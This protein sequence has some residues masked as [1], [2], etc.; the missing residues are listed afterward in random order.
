MTKGYH[1]PARYVIHTVGPLYQGG[2]RGEPELLAACY[3]NCL[4]LAEDNG[5]GSLAF[6]SIGAG[7]YGYPLVEAARIA[8]QTAKDFPNCES[9]LKR[10]VYCCFPPENTEVYRQVYSEIWSGVEGLKMKHL[11]LSVSGRVQGVFFRDTA[12]REAEKLGINGFARNEPNGTVWIEAEGV[13]A[14][15]D[16]FLQ[17]CRRGPT[18]GKVENLVVTEGGLQGFPDFRVRF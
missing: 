10:I 5:I 14:K 8:L 17:W 15:L 7:V 18:W 1:L 3:R 16:E 6:P 2:E 13:E 4:I 11:N 12:R 9:I